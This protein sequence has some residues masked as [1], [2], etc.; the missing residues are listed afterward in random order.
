[1]DKNVSRSRSCTPRHTGSDNWLAQQNLQIPQ[2]CYNP[3]GCFPPLSP[4]FFYKG[5]THSSRPDNTYDL[6]NS[7]HAK[8]TFFS[9]LSCSVHH[10]LHSRQGPFRGP[11]FLPKQYSLI[12]RVQTSYLLKPSICKTQSLPYRWK[13]HSGS[14]Q[15]LTGT[16]PPTT[17][18]AAAAKCRCIEYGHRSAAAAA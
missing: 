17:A 9:S 8:S 11:D 14:L 2:H 7:Y 5:L 18:A 13:R 1:M 10:L 15:T 12:F 16:T 3:E 6:A 4:W